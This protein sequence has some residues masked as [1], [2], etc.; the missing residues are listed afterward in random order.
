LG[1]RSTHLRRLKDVKHKEQQANGCAAV[2]PKPSPAKREADMSVSG[3]PNITVVLS[4]S[5]DAVLRQTAESRGRSTEDVV[6]A[7][8]SQYL[9]WKD[10]DEANLAVR[11]GNIELDPPR[12]L[13]RKNSASVRLTPTEFDLLHYLMLH[14]GLAMAHARILRAVWG[15]E[16][17][18]EL[19]YL[20]TY[21]RLLRKKL[22]DDPAE[23]KYLLTDACY[24]YRFADV[25]VDAKAGTH[26][27]AA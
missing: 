5:L 2:D 8:I 1:W 25:T 19:G 24:G 3:M 26:G 16:Y 13:V 23:P 21:I 7:A 4:P 14:A 10:C 6:S 22:E 18:G 9:D 12:R 27:P 20:R 11:I 17:G 15:V